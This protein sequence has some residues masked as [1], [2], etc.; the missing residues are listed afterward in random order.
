MELRMKDKTKSLGGYARAAKLS[1]EERKI[2]AQ[3]AANARWDK[4]KHVPQAEYSGELIIGTMKFPCSVLSDGSRIL[5]QTDFMEGMGMYYSGWVSANRPVEDIAADIPQFLSFKNLKPFVDRHL[6]DLQEVIVNYRTERGSLARGVRAEIVP[7]I[8]DVWLDADEQGKLGIRQKQV[9]AKAKLIMRALAHV[10]ITA[11]VDE[12]TGYQKDRAIDALAKILEQFIAKELRPWVKT[13]PTEFYEELCRLRDIEFPADREK[14]QNY[15]SYFGHITNDIIYKRLA[16]GVL[17]ELKK[18]TP[19]TQ[20][21]H[22][23]Y[24]F[25]RKLSENI[26]HPKLLAHLDSVVTVMKLT[27]DGDYEGFVKKLDRVKPKYNETME[28]NF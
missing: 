14:R 15:P 16:P 25:H 5:T 11:L 19:K 4:S 21:G 6:G 17:E 2:V 28:L 7:K 24:H 10:G 9:A 20:K 3:K 23:K 12:A 26:G 1:D 22:K 8:C 27:D 18:Q 13:F